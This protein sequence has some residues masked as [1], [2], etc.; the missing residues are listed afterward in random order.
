MKLNEGSRLTRRAVLSGVAS[1]ALVVADRAFGQAV[2][3]LTA[4][5]GNPPSA[6]SDSTVDTFHGVNIP[7]PYRPLEDSSRADV[8]AW[9]DAQD[10]RT[11]ALIDSLPIR[12]QLHD[13]MNAALDYPRTTVPARYGRRY[14]T[15][16]SEGLDD[17]RSAGVQEHPGGPRKTLIDANA[18]S[19][20]G[21]VAIQSIFPDR[22]GTKVAYLLSEAGSD[23]ETMRVR[24]VET[25]QDLPDVLAWCKHTTVAWSRDGYSFYYSRYPGD[26]DPADWNRRGQIVCL[27]RLGEPQSA[28]RVIF[29]Q[30]DARDYYFQVAS[31]ID[32]DLLKIVARVGTSEKAGYFVAP[33]HDAS[34]IVEIFPIGSAGFYPIANVGPTHY[35]ITN[36]DA[37]K[38]RLVRI[39]QSDPKPDRWHT[40]IAESE[41]PLNSA[42]V[43]NSK[44]VVKHYQ[45]VNQRVAIHDLSGKH[46]STVDLGGF[47]SVS[48]GRH[49]RDDD[50]LLLEV[51]DYKQASRIEWLDLET[52]KP[53]LFRP[54]AAKHNLADVVVQQIFV[55]SKDGARVPMTLI[56]QRDI[57][58]DGSNRT[59]L[60]AYGGFGY[61]LWPYYSDKI[62]AWVRMG[63]VYALASIRGGG[64]YG[65]PWHDGGRRTHK[66]ASFDDFIASAEWL[67]AN[68]YT[69]PDRLGINGASN[70]GLLVL[71][72]ML[73]RPEL[74]GAVVSAV[75]VT[76]MLRFTKFTFGINWIPEYG[77][78][79][80]N[81][82]DFKALFA[83]SPLHNIRKG[84]KYPPLLVLTADNDDRVAP[85]HSYKFVATLQALSPEST[86]YLGVERRAG[87]SEG[88]ALGKSINR[89]CDTLAFL[90]DRLGGAMQELP[91]ISRSFD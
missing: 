20:D 22:P 34:Q 91:K 33:L 11:R 17:Q 7:D 69:R 37:P 73:Q 76:D 47:E 45:D 2:N 61:A 44:L 10:V 9:I 66:Q 8:K 54:S 59:M 40:V 58:L 52:G 23:R 64:E 14:F 68:G 89:E 46:L 70:G 30:T 80:A 13:F 67:M 60:N 1:G 5:N 25:G 86:V 43:F 18:L 56:R 74:F 62:A 26:N 6:P 27:H 83:Y 38:W 39:D 82:A 78:P 71:A 75:P 85:A 12:K 42:A 84:V 53:S 31:S 65:Q 16:F 50:H 55:T 81:E 32:A 21:T 36:L 28:D 41:A 24:D 48:F 4:S 57:Q 49:F 35:A 72:A 19:S 29:R 3:G 90:C 77:N 87:H 63:G 88:N 51:N 79:Q 15:L